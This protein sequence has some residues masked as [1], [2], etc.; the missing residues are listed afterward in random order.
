VGKF[1]IGDRVEILFNP[2]VAHPWFGAWGLKGTISKTN[3]LPPSFSYYVE[4]DDNTIAFGGWF[5]GDELE[6]VNTLDRL[7]EEVEHE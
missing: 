7:V 5:Y 4:F 1:N 3:G 6:P 2:P